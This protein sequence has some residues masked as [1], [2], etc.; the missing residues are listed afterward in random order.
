MRFWRAARMTDILTELDAY[1]QSDTC[2][3]DRLGLS[4]LDGFLTGLTCSPHPAAYWADIAFGPGA[5]VPKRIM[6]LV[7]QR[8]DAIKGGLAA[9]KPIL[10]PVFWQAPRGMS[11]LWIGVKCLWKP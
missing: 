11:L 2:P 6:D 9:K 3:S 5:F 1:L 4:D 7:T 10:E 8:L